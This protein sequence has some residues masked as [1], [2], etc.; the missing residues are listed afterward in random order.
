MHTDA[1]LCLVSHPGALQ[2]R[3]AQGPGRHQSGTRVV[4]L[5]SERPQ[6]RPAQRGILL[7]C[8]KRIMASGSVL[9]FFH[10]TTCFMTWQRMCRR[11]D[12]PA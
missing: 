4:F 5:Y 7:S 1:C 11:H 2:L 9:S 3:G 8:L 12:A 6:E 10:A